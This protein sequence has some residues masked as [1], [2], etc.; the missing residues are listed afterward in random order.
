MERN[1]SLFFGVLLVALLWSVAIAYVGGR[2]TYTSLDQDVGMIAFHETAHNL[3]IIGS[4]G[5]VDNLFAGYFRRPPA[6]AL[7]LALVYSVFGEKL[8]AVWGL[9]LALWMLVLFVLWRV[10]TR[11]LEGPYT[12]LPPLLLGFWWGASAQVFIMNP[13]IFAMLLMLCFIYFTLRYGE[14][15][16]ILL[17]LFAGIFLAILVLIKPIFLYFVPLAL[18]VL[19]AQYCIRFS[20]GIMFLAPI[21]VLVGSWMAYSYRVFGTYELASGALTI[22]RRADDVNMSGER[23]RAFIV[24][25]FLGDFNADRIYPGYADDPEPV[26]AESVARERAYIENGWTKG[27]ANEAERQER[28]YETAKELILSNPIKFLALTPIYAIRL[29]MPVNHHGESMGHTFA[30]SDRGLSQ[31]TKTLILSVIFIA[32]YMFI[33]LVWWSYVKRIKA[34][35]QWGIILLIIPYLIVIYALVSHSETRYLLPVMPFYFLL[36]S[37]FIVPILKRQFAKGY[38]QT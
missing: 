2:F 13:E 25:T 16:K 28:T 22:M 29:H 7:L 1:N 6:Y 34:W 20:H 4:F 33:A 5:T 10:S 32:W 8:W 31:N 37:S 27:K 19:F 23:I 12:L 9:H 36:F 35:K 17:L 18:M 3:V 24:A 38:A 26:T 21:I 14:E 30:G 15:K 11:F